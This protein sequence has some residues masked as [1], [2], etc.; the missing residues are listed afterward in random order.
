MKLLV[1]LQLT[2]FSDSIG[3]IIIKDE[4]WILLLIV[5][6]ATVCY[7]RELGSRIFNK[8][9]D[10]GKSKRNKYSNNINIKL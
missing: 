5:L 8:Q 6:F 7:I 9:R 3:Q 4:W 2:I 1:F 10:N